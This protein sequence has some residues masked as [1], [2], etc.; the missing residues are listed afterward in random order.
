METQDLSRSPSWTWN[1]IVSKWTSAYLFRVPLTHTTNSLRSVLRHATR[2]RRL[3]FKQFEQLEDWVH[4]DKPLVVIGEAAHPFTVRH[5]EPM[6]WRRLTNLSQPGSLQG[7]AMAVEDAAVLG[8]LFSHLNTK[9]QIESFLYAFQDLRQARANSTLKGDI[10]NVFTVM[11]E[12]GPFQE[13]RDD[14][15]RQKR[16]QGANLLDQGEGEESKLW[17]EIRTV[18]GYELKWE[19]SDV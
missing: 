7:P 5:K 1:V 15:M 11:L 14:M 19:S 2:A 16:D 3:P 6:V 8:K 4:D 9:E 17:E 18:F 10:E 12:D 13:M